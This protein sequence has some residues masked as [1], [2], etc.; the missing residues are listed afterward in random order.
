MKNQ[1]LK[2]E[3]KDYSFPPIFRKW[4]AEGKMTEAEAERKISE[5]LLN[6]NNERLMLML[7][8]AQEYHQSN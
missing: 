2:G 5:R 8:I 1:I 4:I 3:K 7:C 6:I